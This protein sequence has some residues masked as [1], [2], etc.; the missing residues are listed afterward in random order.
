MRTLISASQLNTELN[1]A[2]LVILDC[3]FYLTDFGKGKQL[4]A[5]GH[6]PGALFV[7]VHGQLAGPETDE[8]GRHPLPDMAGF[9][10]LLSELGISKDSH[11]VV[12]DDMNGAIAARAWWMLSQLD[13]DVRV[14]DGGIQSWTRSGFELSQQVPENQAKPVSFSNAAFLWE[15]SEL[16]VVES[17]EQ[18]SFQ[19]VDARAEDRYLGQNENIDPIAGHIPGAINRPF[20]SNLTAEGVFKAPQTLKEEWLRLTDKPEKTVQYCG[21]GVTAC[22]NVLSMAIAGFD[23]RKVYVG[24]WSQW[25]KRMVRRMKE[26]QQDN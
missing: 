8:S 21:S 14:L 15:V 7:D 24:S 16:S 4:Y 19:L 6:I 3:R 20:M 9:L 26:A 22:H 13:V 2:N 10:F 23:T 1:Q 12:Y 5:E 17:F 11:I 25:S 18:A